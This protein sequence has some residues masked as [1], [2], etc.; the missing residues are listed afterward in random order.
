MLRRFFYLF[1]MVCVLTGLLIAQAGCTTST[2]GPLPSSNNGSGGSFAPGEN[3]TPVPASSLNFA[4]VDPNYIYTQLLYMATHFVHRE[5][6][7]DTNLAS[8]V[9]GHDEFASYWTQTMLNTFQ[10]FGAQV[11]RDSFPT[12]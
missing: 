2:P 12:G 8:N 3:S 5:A 4:A 6:G 9:N 7:F 1:L 11:S 10:G